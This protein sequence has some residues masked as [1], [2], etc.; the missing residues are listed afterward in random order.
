MIGALL[1]ALARPALAAVERFAVLVGNN[2]GTAREQPLVFAQQDAREMWQVLTSVGR[3]KPEDATLLLGA[4]RNDVLEAFARVRAQVAQAHQRGDDTVVVFFYSGHADE[5]RLQLGRTWVTWDELDTL[6]ERT[7]ADVRIALIDACHSGSMTRN[8][9]GTRTSGFVVDLDQHLDAS[10]QVVITSSAGN[11]A[12]QESEEIGGGYFTHFLASALKGAA[13]DDGDGKVTLSEAYR[14]VYR[15]TVYQTSTTRVGAQHP[16]FDWELTGQGD[17]VLSDL[18]AVGSRLVFPPDAPGRY[19]VFDQAR[20]QFVAEVDAGGQ[21][22]RLALAPGEYLV[23]ERLP[24]HMQVAEVKLDPGGTASIADLRFGVVQYEDDPVRGIMERRVRRARGPRLCALVEAGSRAFRDPE[25]TAQW[26]PSTPALGV[27]LRWQ[28]RRGPWLAADVL[29]GAGTGLL[30]FSDL[31]YQVPVA[32]SGGTF[33]AAAGWATPD[34]IVR[35][36][37]GV[38]LAAV[39]L[40]RSFPGED[41]P[42][43]HLFTIAPGLDLWVGLEPGRVSLELELRSHYLPYILEG[44]DRGVS[45]TEGLLAV[46]WRF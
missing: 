21:E 29:P 20:R 23:Q 12:S 33:G 37:A 24:S 34:A 39:Y 27:E 44:H 28:W 30:S 19:L 40:Q 14:Y 35:A 10:G 7:G 22:H 2:E 42:A 41:L 31:G 13:D 4:R 8:K 26:F 5:Y 32:V 25:V 1:L 9:G 18:S 46:G 43:Q 16:T 15:E 45:F 17:V 6:V 36:G 11:E 3:V 38:R